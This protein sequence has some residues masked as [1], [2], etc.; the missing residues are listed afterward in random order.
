MLGCE[1]FYWYRRLDEF[2]FHSPERHAFSLPSPIPE[3]PP[4]QG[5]ATGRIDLGELEVTKITKFE[6][7]W[8]YN[9]LCGKAKGTTFYRPLGIPDCFFCLGYY[10]QPNDRPLRGYVLVAREKSVSYPNVGCPLGFKPELPALM[11]PLNYKL[12]WSTESHGEGCGFFWLPNPPA[13]YKAMG[14]VVTDN[15]EE[16]EVEEIR[17]V[18]EDLTENCEICDCMLTTDTNPFQVWKTRPCKR[19]MFARGVSVGTFFCGICL[20][21]EDQLDFAC[22]KN[23]EST[24][25]GMPNLDQVHALINHYGPTVFFHPDDVYMP[26]S[27]QWFFKN[28]ALLYKYGKVK[29]EPINYQGANLPFGGKN[30]GAFWIDLPEDDDARNN[31]KKGNLESAELYVHVKPALGGTFTDIAM[32]VF[33]PFNGPATLKIGLMSIQMSKIGQHVGDWEHFTLRVSNF[34]GELWQVYFSQ[35]SGG[36]WV[37]ATDLEFIEG[38]KPIVYSSKGGHASFAHPGTYLQGSVELGI[39][40]RNDA[41]RSKYVVDSSAKYQIIAAEYLGHEVTEPCWL[42][43]MREWG[44]TIVYDS[45]S[46]LDKII[47]LLPLFV[48]FSVE[49]IFDLFPMQLYGE[50]GPTGPK[51]KDNWEEDERW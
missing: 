40:V 9:L 31:V 20:S 33:C 27:V 15:P 4:G 42:Q 5:F 3:W 32:W 39:G 1:C 51:E 8:S 19:G 14:L 29:G 43:Y 7:I 6:R 36:V 45:R 17:C 47:N 49:N 48:R 44:P 37:D 24:L 41:A 22:L 23:L 13:G 26:S 21:S 12:I 34:T 2:H 46:E 10:C 18:R 38:N 35:H 30:D 50:E 16:P 28:G 25:H 11:K